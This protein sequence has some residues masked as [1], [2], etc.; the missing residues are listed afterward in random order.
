MKEFNLKE[1]VRTNIWELQPYSS[2]RDEFTGNEGIFL[3]ANEN[4]YGENNRY[5]DPHQRLLKESLSE[6]KNVPAENI[7]IGNGS[8]EVIDLI[9]RIFCEPSKD[10]VIICPPTY[11]MYEVSANINNAKTIKIP[12]DN[13]FQLN[14]E[15]IFKQKAK[16]IFICSPNNPTGNSI[17]DIKLV[18]NNFKGLVIVDEAYIDFS[19]ISSYIYE[20]DKF[21]NLIVMQTFSKAWGLASARVGVAYASKEI[22]SLMSK[23]K[24]PYNVS[25]LNQVKAIETLKNKKLFDDQ[26]QTI[27][28]QREYLKREITKL[29]I[30]KRIYPSDANFIL[31]EVDD[32]NYVY[33]KLINAKII[34]RN[35]T[36]QINNCIRITI[37]TPEENQSLINE[38]KNI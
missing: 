22:I 10:S 15:E 6:I 9:F 4:P 7:F 25:T 38:I 26:L 1:L 20:L 28:E 5:P 21:P 35:R 14:T 30:V 11:G 17:N 18:L 23:T 8:D 12:L 33:N 19:N 37:G 3:D 2:A 16:A 27:L 29:N 13:N 31:I 34:T 24:P 32:A 36:S